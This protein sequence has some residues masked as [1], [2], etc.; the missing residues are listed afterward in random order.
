[1]T[2]INRKDGSDGVGADL[3]TLV[4]KIFKPSAGG[5]GVA[6]V[7]PDG[8]KKGEQVKAPDADLGK[9]APGANV[10]AYLRDNARK[11]DLE[12]NQMDPFAV[13]AGWFRAGD[14]RADMLA[15]SAAEASAPEAVASAD[16]AGET[17]INELTRDQDLH[18]IFG[19]FTQKGNER[20][21]DISKGPGKKD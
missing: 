8:Y 11:H 20:I 19:L 13:V 14:A 4:G 2:R 16:R 18:D 1:M 17:H 6:T 7:G 3:A 9:K 5:A 10:G 15:R 12:P 21:K